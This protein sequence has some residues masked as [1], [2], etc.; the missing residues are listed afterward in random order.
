MKSLY[1]RLGGLLSLLTSQ[2]AL[3]SINIDMVRQGFR[4]H[5]Q[6]LDAVRTLKKNNVNLL[7]DLGVVGPVKER[8]LI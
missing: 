4:V 2:Q 7:M 1:N 6:D 5:W 3:K 8:E